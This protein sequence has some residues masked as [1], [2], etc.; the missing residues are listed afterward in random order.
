M[1]TAC[2]LHKSPVCNER[3]LW[4]DRYSSLP[5]SSHTSLKIFDKKPIGKGAWASC[6]SSFE[7][8]HAVF[9]M[10]SIETGQ[11]YFVR[12]SNESV[13]M[14][15]LL[16]RSIHWPFTSPIPCILY[17]LTG[18]S[19][20]SPRIEILPESLVVRS[21]VYLNSINHVQ[22]NNSRHLFSAF[23]DTTSYPLPR[24]RDISASQK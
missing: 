3:S 23:N 15:L 19:F 24:E 16:A 21:C 6:K 9:H 17:F 5:V 10:N 2:S 20:H 8:S 4:L 13:E 22:A 12:L 1:C 7:N 14:L 18:S 11:L